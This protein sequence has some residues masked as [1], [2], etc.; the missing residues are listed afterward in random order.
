[1]NDIGATLRLLVKNNFKLGK[2]ISKVII[3]VGANDTRLCQLEAN[4]I[5]IESVCNHAKM[6]PDTTIA[7]SVCLHVVASLLTV[8]VVP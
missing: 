5:N 2:V 8:K 6:I 4:I 1:M 7:F 3:D